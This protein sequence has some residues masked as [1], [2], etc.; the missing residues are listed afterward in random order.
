[1]P[2]T[3]ER[4]RASS[5]CA[6]SLSSATAASGQRSLLRSSCSS[7]ELVASEP[8]GVCRSRTARPNRR[9]PLSGR[10][11]WHRKSDLPTGAQPT[12]GMASLPATMLE[13]RHSVS[14][15]SLSACTAAGPQCEKRNSM[16]NG[17]SP[18]PRRAVGSAPASSSGATSRCTASPPSRPGRRLNR[19]CR[20]VSPSRD[21]ALT[22]APARISARM[23]QSTAQLH[24]QCS[25]VKPSQSVHAGEAP[26]SRRWRVRC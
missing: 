2:R 6:F 9:S 8:A 7:E 5:S 13:G 18:S 14:S 1:M 3:K 22:G 16:S 26:H 20:G 10:G 24:A 21:V 15:P 23:A 25:G 17:R 12:P 4:R 19:Q 11:L